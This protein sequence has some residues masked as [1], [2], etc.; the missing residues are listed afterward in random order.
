[1]CS[2][3]AS[4]VSNFLLSKNET[5]GS[6]GS[7]DFSSSSS[8]AVSQPLE[9][10][11]PALASSSSTAMSFPAAK[12]TPLGAATRKDAAVA[13]SLV[14][15]VAIAGRTFVVVACC[16]F[17]AAC[18]LVIAPPLPPPSFPFPFPPPPLLLSSECTTTK[19]SGAGSPDFFT[20][21][22]YLLEETKVR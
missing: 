5:V 3:Q 12:V 17:F 6:Q 9:P 13:P 15:G 21:S 1:M 11:P 7:T 14:V 8:E 4:T 18:D 22:L 16:L 2:R 20:S 19:A 10:S